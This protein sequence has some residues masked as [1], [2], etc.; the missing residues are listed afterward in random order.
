MIFRKKVVISLLI[1]VCIIIGII[2]GHVIYN[3]LQLN[4]TPKDSYL[5]NYSKADLKYA[6]TE[7]YKKSSSI[8]EL[9]KIYFKALHNLVAFHT[10]YAKYEKYLE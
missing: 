6:R 9:T 3:D 10:I 4:K 7:L 5:N 1:S 2:F 8:E